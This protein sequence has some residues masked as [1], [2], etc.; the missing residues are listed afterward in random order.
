[1][2]GWGCRDGEMRVGAAA[3]WAMWGC[4]DGEMRVGVV[5]GWAMIGRGVRARLALCLLGASHPPPNLP[6]ERGEG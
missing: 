2:A 6:P 5:A 3:G 4:R 1:M